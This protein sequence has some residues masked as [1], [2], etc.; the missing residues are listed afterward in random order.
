VVLHIGGFGHNLADKD[1]I[2]L[3]ICAIH[4]RNCL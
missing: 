2:P 4:A 3:R 1:Y